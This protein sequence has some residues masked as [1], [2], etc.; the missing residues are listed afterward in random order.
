MHKNVKL[1]CFAKKN[2]EKMILKLNAPLKNYVWGGTKLKTNYGKQCQT[3]V[4]ESWELSFVPQSE[5]VVASGVNKGK[6]LPEVVTS[7]DLGKNCQ[8]FDIFPTLIKFINAEQNLSVQVHPSDSYAKTHENALGK[9]EMWYVLD[10]EPNAKLYLG[11]NKSVTKEQFC[12]AV[13]QNRV[14][15]LL[16]AVPVAAGETYFVLSG[17]LHAIGAGITLLEIQQNSTLTYR[18]YDYG[19]LVDGKPRELH[20][21]KA[22]DV[23]NLE[24][25]NVPNPQRE[26]FL[27]GCKYF[28][29][30]RHSGAHTFCNADSFSSVTVVE[31]SVNLNGLALVKGET[32]FVSAG[33]K[34]EISGNGSYVITCVE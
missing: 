26:S 21:Q 4:A 5:S 13:E 19:R 1:R 11:L 10:A 31:G 9:T 3:N 25:Y 17:T 7:A 34:A 20:L 16:N 32:A 28:S 23:A 18:V 8:K 14:I 12:A 15:E 29:A 2:I 24:K 30:Y 22:L 27:G 33:E 6:I